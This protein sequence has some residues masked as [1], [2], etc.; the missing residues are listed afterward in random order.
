MLGKLIKET[1]V[2]SLDNFEKALYKVLPE[3]HHHLIPDE[4]KALNVG[5]EY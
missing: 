2:V 3:K 5:M 4:L 1:G